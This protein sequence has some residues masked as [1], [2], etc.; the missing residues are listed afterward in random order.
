MTVHP[1]WRLGKDA[2]DAKL[3]EAIPRVRP[4]AVGAG[5]WL[6]GWSRGSRVTLNTA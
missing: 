1:V 6:E 3:F 2:L 4:K 5:K